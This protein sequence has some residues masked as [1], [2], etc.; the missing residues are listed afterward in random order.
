MKIYVVTRGRY[1]DCGIITATTD[2]VLANKIA[3]KFEDTEINVFENAE[4]FLT[5]CWLVRF[6]KAG[7]A[8]QI[9]NKSSEAMYYK[10]LNQ[11]DFD[12]WGQVFVCVL[13]ANADSAVNVAAKCR[14]D[15]LAE[16]NG[17]QKTERDSSVGGNNMNEVHYMIAYLDAEGNGFQANPFILDSCGNNIE[18]V[19][20]TKRD[21][22][23]SGFNRVT[24]FRVNLDAIPEEITWDFVEANSVQSQS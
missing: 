13:A 16:K 5:P 19:E 21:M 6:D 14:D 15:F 20:N 10:D 9:E 11:C 8:I 23:L 1:D 3:A 2:D 4:M 7:N 12:F 22:I 17:T 18:E 24:I